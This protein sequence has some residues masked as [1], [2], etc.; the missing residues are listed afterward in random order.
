MI[1][2]SEGAGLDVPPNWAM[3]DHVH[4]GAVRPWLDGWWQ[5]R[6]LAFLLDEGRQ[7]RPVKYRPTD[8][9]LCEQCFDQ[10]RNANLTILSIALLRQRHSRISTRTPI[11][12]PRIKR[13]PHP[14]C[15]IADRSVAR[16]S[17]ER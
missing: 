17:G 12:A 11:S 9:T 16:S 2:N 15:S 1:V 3:T 13:L 10:D 6:D 7:W 4:E 5:A 8:A 14:R